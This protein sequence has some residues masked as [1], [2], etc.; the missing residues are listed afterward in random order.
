M[1]DLG[2]DVFDARDLRER[3]TGGLR[4]SGREVVFLVGSGLTAP[5]VDG[6]PGVP[7]VWGVIDL[8]EREFD[9]E[10]RDELRAECAAAENAYQA[11]FQFMLRRRGQQEVNGIIRKAVARARLIP[12]DGP[13]APYVIDASTPEDVCRS[14]DSDV[15]GWHLAPGVEALGRLA[16]G[17]RDRFGGTVL[18]TNF[19]PLASVAIAK[20]G[21]STFRTMLHRDGD[22][23]QSIGEATQVV[24]LH[25]YWHGVDTLHTPRQLGQPRPQLKASLA[26][27]IRDRTVVVLAYGGWDDVFTKALVDVVVEDG[28][29]PE[30]VWTLREAAPTLRPSLVDLLAPG[31]DRGRVAFYGGVECHTFLPALAREWSS[32]ASPGSPGLA[33]PAPLVVG[34]GGVVDA[35]GPVAR[36]AAGTAGIEASANLIAVPQ[37]GPSLAERLALVSGQE[38]RPPEIDVYVGRTGDLAKLTGSPFRVAYVT[39]IGGQGKSALAGAFFH[40]AEASARFDHRLWRDCKEQSFRFEDHV[41]SILEAL[42]GDDGVLPADLASQSPHALARLFARLTSDLRLL[43]VFDNVDHYVD[44]ERGVLL[45][46]AGDFVSTLLE[47]PSHAG[48]V[49]TCRPNMASGDAQV[50]SHR[51]EGLTAAET[52]ELF[53][54][55]GAAAGWDDVER[56]GALTEG[57]ALWLD[58]IAAQV[59]RRPGSERLSELLD[60]IASGGGRIP[61]ATLK[62]IWSQLADREQLVLQVLAETV[63]PT[64]ALQVAD[65]L[66]SR[67]RYNRVTKAVGQLRSMNLVVVK[68]QEGAEAYELHPLIRTF[69]RRTHRKTDRVWFIDAILSVYNAMFDLQRSTLTGRTPAR[70]VRHWLEGVELHVNAERP[71]AAIA[72]LHEINNAATSEAPVEFARV[73]GLVFDRDDLEAVASLPHFDDV[74][75]DYVRTLAAL[76]ATEEAFGALERYERTLSGKEVRYI[77]LCD[78]RCYLHWWNRNYDAAIKWGSEGVA[79]KKASGVDTAFDSAHNLALAQRDAGLVDPALRYFLAGSSLEEVTRPG[80]LEEER[81]ESFYGNIGRCLHFMGQV[82]PALACYRTSATLAQESEAAYG[83]EN[84]AFIREW[85][86]ELLEAR[87]DTAAAVA[88]LAASAAKWGRIS[89]DRSER[90]AARATSLAASHPTCGTVPDEQAAEATV[91]SW[92]AGNV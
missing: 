13:A 24:H 79:L 29:F 72:S 4:A 63:R 6:G 42:G 90:V 25:G 48:L 66:G 26:K 77:S 14:F 64:T 23:G 7:G 21:G 35:T 30:V 76:G 40:S 65:Y 28:S 83:L 8:I 50:L 85:I 22:I 87:G 73:A 91:L 39:G 49:F 10:Q 86:G 69:V 58:L 3:L 32:S 47:Y 19:D 41:V 1:G 15:N 37:A 33:I 2:I 11:A 59:A 55:R 78:M 27:L 46:A 74:F 84:Q 82:D 45:G 54:R 18:T 80:G 67:L 17:W 5:T 71:D 61:E 12:T 70:T 88:F 20:A 36:I 53:H 89:P 56:A 34:S 92:I 9:N 62:S 16:A 57:H 60:E 75:P 51:V 52:L 43:V 68:R 31:I 38:D 81:S 44:L